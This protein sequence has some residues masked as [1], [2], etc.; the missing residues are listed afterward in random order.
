M[1]L[2]IPLVQRISELHIN[3]KH[4][5]VIKRLD[6][7]MRQNEKHPAVKDFIGLV[8]THQLISRNVAE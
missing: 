2:S 8:N 7:L 4:S 3:D 5:D 6:G 1:N